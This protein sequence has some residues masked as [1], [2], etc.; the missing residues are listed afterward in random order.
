MEN[1]EENIV[2]VII[3]D[4]PDDLES[5]T[6]AINAVTQHITC[7]TA[8]SGEEGLQKLDALENPPQFIFLDINMPAMNGWECLQEI[9]KRE[10]LRHV[11]IIVLSTAQS[12]KTL[13]ELRQLEIARY[14][15]K[16]DNLEDLSKAIARVF[17]REVIL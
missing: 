8:N 4:D 14:I 2:C 3:D 6:L 16:P 11:P 13:Q 15:V 1:S 7:I 12:F 10:R 9:K 17:V 5:F